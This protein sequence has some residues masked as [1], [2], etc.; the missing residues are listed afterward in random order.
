VERLSDGLECVAINVVLV[1]GGNIV[2]I[3]NIDDVGYRIEHVD[4]IRGIVN[5]RRD[6]DIE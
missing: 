5:K 3:A 6:D 2:E 4:G 1:I